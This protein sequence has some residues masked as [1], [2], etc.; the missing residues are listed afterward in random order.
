MA[1]KQQHLKHRNRELARYLLNS[2]NARDISPLPPV[3]HHS[4]RVLCSH[5]LRDY[6]QTYHAKTFPLP[7]SDN[8]LEFINRLESVIKN[9]GLVSIAMPRGTGKTSI[10]DFASEWAVLNSWRRFVLLISSTATEA[11]RNMNAIKTSLLTNDLLPEDYPEVCYPIRKMEGRAIS[12]NGQTFYGRSTRIKWGARRI[13][14]PTI[15]GSES[16]GNAIACYGI[17]SSIRGV[18]EDMPDGSLIRPDFLM[19]DDLQKDDLAINP[20]RV[21]RLEEIVNST[22]LG[23]SASDKTISSVMTCTVIQDGDLADRFLSHDIYPQWNGLRFKMVP[24]M[25]V[26]MDLWR[27]YKGLLLESPHEATD[28]YKSNKE[29]MRRGAR[30]S[31]PE[32]FDKNESI[33]ALQHS[34]N[35]WARN[36]RSFQSEYQNE[37][38]KAEGSNIQIPSRVIAGKLNG[39]RRYELPA[40]TAKVTA[41]IDV[42]QD[43]L[44]YAVA[45]IDPHFTVSIIDYGTLPEQNRSYFEK[46]DTGLNTLQE[47]FSGTANEAI[48]SGLEMLSSFLLNQEYFEDN[49]QAGHKIDAVFI[50]GRFKPEVVDSAIEAVKSPIIHACRGVGIRATSTPMAQWPQRNARH[51]GYHWLEEKTPGSKLRSVMAD[52]NFWKSRVHESFGLYPGERGSLTLWGSDKNSH[53]MFADHMGAETVKLVTSN[54]NSVF[55]W[56]VKPVQFDNHYFDCCVGCLVA[57]SALGIRLDTQEVMA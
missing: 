15:Y 17:T 12:A 9:G 21:A 50:D 51:F 39:R 35:K 28:F 7:F 31:W 18:N 25:P 37:P 55:E 20:A 23:L 30:V 57:G 4:R 19:L 49:A 26:R 43:L 27:E 5:S 24:Q 42:H 34:M 3:K 16:S 53:R 44:Y 47:T 13:K 6:L 52:T 38:I 14:L 33:D 22:L 10:S 56:F 1:N 40:N 29:E 36:E 45:A 46:G 2:A 54:G 32:A 11:E 41:F 48:L 8:H